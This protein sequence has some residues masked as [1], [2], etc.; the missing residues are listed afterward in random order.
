VV[1]VVADVAHLRAARQAAVLGGTAPPGLRAMELQACRM[2]D[3]VL[4]H[5]P[6]EAALLRASLPGLRVHVVPWHAAARPVAVPFAARSGV[7]FVG[8]YGHAPN[9]DAARF[10]LDAVMPEVW[11]HAPVPWWWPGTGCPRGWPRARPRWCG[12]C[13]S[14]MTWA[15]CGGRCGLAWRR[16]ASA[17]G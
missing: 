3:A 1:F 4:T 2:A 5:S 16:C 7:G 12:C 17:R 10:L 13:R 15:I 6:V 14:W 8:S 11:R 9:P